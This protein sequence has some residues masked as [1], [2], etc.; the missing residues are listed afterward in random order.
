M[1]ITDVIPKYVR[2]ASSNTVKNRGDTTRKH[3]KDPRLLESVSLASK[4]AG[5]DQI[6]LED[7]TAVNAFKQKSFFFNSQK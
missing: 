1:D 4:G 6:E 5:L 3:V 2:L 7:Q